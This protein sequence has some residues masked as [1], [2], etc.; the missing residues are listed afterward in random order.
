MY[1][2]G[3]HHMSHCKMAVTEE[4]HTPLEPELL[5]WILSVVPITAACIV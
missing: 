3:T 1:G 5:F 4:W 2:D